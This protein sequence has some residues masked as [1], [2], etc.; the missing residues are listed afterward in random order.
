MYNRF[1]I[2]YPQMQK[3]AEQISYHLDIAKFSISVI[4]TQEGKTMTMLLGRNRIQDIQEQIANLSKAV[5]FQ[6]SLEMC[7]VLKLE[8]MDPVSALKARRV[9][10]DYISLTNLTKKVQ[11]GRKLSK[12]ETK[13]VQK[14]RERIGEL[15]DSQRTAFDSFWEVL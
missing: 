2:G 12:K 10:R 13:Y 11:N 4:R 7:K 15:S 9:I 3:L 5:Y 8:V 14:S 1:G 6:I